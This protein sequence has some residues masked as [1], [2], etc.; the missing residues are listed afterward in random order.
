MTCADGPLPVGDIIFLG[1][2]AI[3]G[4][5]Y[6]V[7]D[8]NVNLHPPMRVDINIETN[9]IQNSNLGLETIPISPPSTLIETIPIESIPIN[10]ETYPVNIISRPNIIS[11]GKENQRLTK[12]R[13]FTNEQIIELYKDPNI[14][15]KEKKDLVKE[16]K[17]R[18][19]RD[20]NKRKELY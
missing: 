2:L 6:L 18:K 12:Y 5:T 16:Q 11:K 15:K 8:S 10:V 9:P 3:L 4:I 7:K 13:G 14:S 19:I 17:A 20:V 1:G